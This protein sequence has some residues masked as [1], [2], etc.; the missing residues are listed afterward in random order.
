MSVSYERARNLYKTAPRESLIQLRALTSEIAIE[1]LSEHGVEVPKV[2]DLYG[3]LTLLEAKQY[4]SKQ[5]TDLLHGIRVRG[6]K[7]AHPEQ[8]NIKQ[9]N[10]VNLAKE[11]LLKFC[12]VIDLIRVS[13]H[14]LSPL[15][16]EF[17]EPEEGDALKDISYKALFENEPSAKYDVATLLLNKNFIRHNQEL[18]RVGQSEI[19]PLDYDRNAVYLLESM[20]NFDHLDSRYMLGHL[21]MVGIGCEYDPKK[22]FEHLY[23]AASQNHLDAQAY[24]GEAAITIKDYTEEYLIEKALDFLESA[25]KLDNPIAQNALSKIFAEGKHVEKDMKRSVS[26]LMSAANAG[27]PESQCKLA[28]YYKAQNDKDNFWLYIEKAV[29]NGSHSAIRSKAKFLAEDNHTEKALELYEE[30]LDYSYDSEGHFEMVQLLLRI[31]KHN[32]SNFEKGLRGLVGCYQNQNTAPIIRREIEKLSRK[33]LVQLESMIEREPA[34]I[35]KFR[36]VF[37]MFKA[38]G[39]PFK[40]AYDCAEAMM[41]VGKLKSTKS[42]ESA[43]DKYRKTFYTPRYCKKPVVVNNLFTEDKV[44]RNEPCPCKSGKKFKKCCGS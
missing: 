13:I 16:I 21:Y 30:Y 31:G 32:P 24:F 25:A 11:G 44:G 35:E 1:I 8:F 29:E 12:N 39:C 15:E 37:M 41:E 26:L 17:V 36:D 28:E 14:G 23:H 9:E 20:S 40:T 3:V 34:L 38:N 2:Q 4:V 42:T 18:S 5:I 6:N 19:D 43:L 27:L 10:L 33:S 22:A 7:A